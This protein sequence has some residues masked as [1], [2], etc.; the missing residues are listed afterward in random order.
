M[1]GDVAELSSLN[2]ELLVRLLRHRVIVRC[3]SI[4]PVRVDVR[5]VASTRRDLALAVARGRFRQDLYALLR[6]ASLLVPPLRSRPADIP[7]LVDRVV[8]ARG[9]SC[10]VD[11]EAM[12]ALLG[13][14]WPGNVRE[15]RRVVE[16]AIASAGGGAIGVEHLRLRR[17][18]ARDALAVDPRRVSTHPARS[19]ETQRRV[20]AA[21]LEDD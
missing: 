3:R 15:L 7:A 20:V 21:A 5:V 8:R 12:A 11:P 4:R 17:S 18:G 2:Q 19:V 16:G 13:Y 1:L 14:P 9:G 6:R 10:Q